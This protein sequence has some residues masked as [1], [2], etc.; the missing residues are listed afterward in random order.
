MSLISIPKLGKN[1]KLPESYR[2]IALLSSLSKIYERSILQKLHKSLAGKIGEEQF[3]FCQHHSTTLQLTKFVDQVS[4]NLNLGQHTAAVF[5]DVEKAFDSVW[6][7]G[8][9][10][11]MIELGVPLQLVK[12]TES[13]LSER[14]FLVKIENKYSSTTPANA[15]VP[16]GSC[17]SPTLFNIYTNDMP[18][19]PRAHVSM[20]ADDTM[21]H[22]TNHN[23]RYA[24]IQLQRQ[25][26]LASELFIKWRLCINESKTI[27]ILFSRKRTSSIHQL[28]I[29][30]VP[31]TWSKS[32]KYL[33]VTID[34]NLNFSNH[35]S[36][37]VKKATKIRGLLYPVLNKRF[38]IHLLKLYI[39]PIL[40]Y[41]GAAWAPFIFDSSWRK[42]E[43]VI[44]IAIRNILGQ[45]RIVRNSVL[46]NTTGFD[47][48]QDSIKK[49]AA[50]M[51]HIIQTSRF[52]HIRNIGQINPSPYMSILK[53]RPR[54]KL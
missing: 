11:K 14:T 44:T 10:H 21:F 8:L 2:P 47:T 41:A 36:N 33:G 4:T 17:L 1:H 27:A 42:I 46:R 50:A 3:A 19:N 16:Q 25:L 23:A 37:I 51:F 20:F 38:P 28:K 32:V 45:P 40:S 15:G 53:Q 43:A 5:L 24:S 39:Q 6:H 7:D 34:Q 26:N 13:F 12:I 48:V 35:A 9:L 29:N 18:T 54:V 31:I 22:C 49:N 30:N 52:N